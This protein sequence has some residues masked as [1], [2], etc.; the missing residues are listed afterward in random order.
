MVDG[1]PSRSKSV[2]TTYA[3][4]MALPTFWTTA[5]AKSLSGDQPCLLST[6]IGGRYK[7]KRP[8]ENAADLATW[9][10]NHTTQLTEAVDRLK[11]EGWK[12]SVE[13]FFK[14][15]G[16]HAIIS[17]KADCIAQ[18]TDKRPLIMDVKS[19]EPRDSDVIQVAIEMVMIPLAW[20]S[21]SMIFDGGVLYKGHQ[22]Q[23]TPAHAADLRPKIVALLKKLGTIPRPEASPSLSACRFCDVP[24]SL[25]PD[26]VTVES[27]PQ[28]VSEVSL[29]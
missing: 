6:W 7:E 12:C 23:V 14:V 8:R 3:D 17:G 5:I 19:G 10:V 27:E 9:K 18:Q 24:E 16:Q 11:A 22:V 4:E 20:E 21:P 26:R 13:R 2:S 29:F 28:Q 15:T 1:A 25:C